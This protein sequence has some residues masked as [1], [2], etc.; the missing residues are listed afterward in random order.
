LKIAR[1]IEVVPLEVER[2]SYF[3]TGDLRKGT[4]FAVQLKLRR[5]IAGE[6]GYLQ[7]FSPNFEIN[8]LSCFPE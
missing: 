4:K 1:N 3:V 8:I 2:T 5:F 7:E 6:S